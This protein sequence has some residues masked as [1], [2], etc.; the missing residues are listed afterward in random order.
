MTFLCICWRRDYSTFIVLEN[1]CA[2]VKST[3]RLWPLSM[4]DKTAYSLWLKLCTH[5]IAFSLHASL[6]HIYIFQPV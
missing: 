4:A 2:I 3:Q 6:K 1:S 5:S